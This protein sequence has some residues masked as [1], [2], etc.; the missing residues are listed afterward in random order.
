M[1]RDITIDIAPGEMLAL[2]GASGTGKST[3]LRLVAGLDSPTQGQIDIDGKPLRGFDSRCAV[4]FQEPRLL[5]WRTLA[6]NVAYGLPS[7]TSRS[8]GQAAVSHWLDV[9][10]LQGFERHRPR[11]VVGSG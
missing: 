2:L 6:G 11:Q 9:V 10:G 4:V 1:L 7:G 3:L 8:H 5:P